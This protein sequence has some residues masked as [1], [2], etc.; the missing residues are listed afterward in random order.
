MVNPNNN[1]NFNNETLRI[2]RQ[3]KK[4]L[5]EIYEA[6][7]GDSG[8]DRFTHEQ[9]IVVLL[10]I[11]DEAH[12]LQRIYQTGLGEKLLKALTEEEEY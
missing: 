2:N 4:E 8:I 9:F 12:L 1:D 7:V 6:I 10:E 11:Y 5:E 3:L